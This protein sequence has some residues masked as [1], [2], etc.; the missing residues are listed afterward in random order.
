MAEPNSNPTTPSMGLAH[1]L[2][3]VV[4]LVA[5]LRAMVAFEPTPGWGLDPFTIAAPSGAFGPREAAVLDVL[6]LVLTSIVL[7]LAPSTK[8]LRW[9][10]YAVA[11]VL[12]TLVGL[13]HG[14]PDGPRPAD[15]SPALAWLAALAGAGAIVRGATQAL[16]RRLVFALLGGVTAM[17]VTKGLVQLLVEHPLTLAQFEANREQMLAAQ[18]LT[19]GSAGARAFERRL[20][21]PEVTGWIGFSNVVASFLAAGGVAL[22][23]AALSGRKVVAI[24]AGVGALVSLGLV[25]YGGSK[26]AMVAGV[27]GLGLVAIGRFAPL[28][29]R[30]GRVRDR[31]AGV[32]ALLVVAGPIGALMARGMVGEAIGEL[33]LLFRWFYIEAASRIALDSPLL[34]VGPGGF[35]DAYA[36][37]KNPISP[38]NAASPHS[39]VFD[40]AA[41]MGVVVGLAVLAL[42]LFAGGGAARALLARNTEEPEPDPLPRLWLLAGPAMAVALGARFEIASVGGLTPALVM[43]WIGG[44]TGWIV[45]AWALWHAPRRCIAIGSGAAALLLIAHGQIEMTPVLIGSASLF[46]AWLGLAVSCD[47]DGDQ[48]RVPARRIGWVVGAVPGLLALCVAVLALPALWS[49]QGAMRVAADRARQPAEYRTLLEA[50]GGDPR[51]FRAVA[52]ELSQTLG[53]RVSPGNLAEG[54]RVL[55]ART[56]RQAAEAMDRAVEAAPADGPTLRTASRA[57]LIASVGRD[58][59]ARQRALDLAQRA[60]EAE[61]ISGQNFSH[62][63]TV[64]STLDPDSTNGERV[65]EALSRAEA[66]N[67]ASPQLKYRRFAIARDLGL[68]AE[69]RRSAAAALESDE[70]MRLDRLGAGLSDEQRGE[71]EAFLADDSG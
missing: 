66:L 37:A 12:V 36:L 48:P 53:Q 24:I 70:L 65:L 32:L 40:A 59:V 34:G 6:T 44:L 41:T 60:A 57:W 2:T 29:L 4:A 58:E 39:I 47:A 52:E 14:L 8:W 56:S 38:E 42:V 16:T 51:V 63:A 20:R 13:V 7:L 55:S 69:A 22:A 28:A 49:W 35:K 50:S 61:P 10:A 18:G 3:V 68:L 15:L 54:L 19:D 26:G 31:V 71:L 62:L 17:F 9:S 21:Q 25:V 33:S 43:A 27:L 45:L 1:G 64:L 11:L 46:A 23:A 5:C 67:P 30:A